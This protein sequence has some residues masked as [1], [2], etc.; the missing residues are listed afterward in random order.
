MFYVSGFIIIMVWLL[1]FLT[2]NE[3]T[4]FILVIFMLW[5]LKVIY[6]YFGKVN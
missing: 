3:I 4:G 6:K 2:S 5:F 1:G